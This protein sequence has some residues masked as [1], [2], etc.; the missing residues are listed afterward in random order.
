M[1]DAR[2]NAP[3]HAL[4]L[5]RV[6][7]LQDYED[8][9]R[10]FGPIAKARADWVW[11]GSGRTVYLT[12]AGEDGAPLAGSTVLQDLKVLLQTSGDAFVRLQVVD[13]RAAEFTLAVRVAKKPDRKFAAVR[14]AVEAALRASFGFGARAFGQSISI[15]CIGY[16]TLPPT[17]RGLRP[18][19][20]DRGRTEKCCPRSCLR[21]RAAQSVSRRCHEPRR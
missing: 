21:S 12:V 17:S 18:R 3:L 4:T 5:G 2:D 20:R 1:A 16:P 7:S 15:C 13:H 19:R 14:E 6:V 10:S 9:A 11:S 8:F